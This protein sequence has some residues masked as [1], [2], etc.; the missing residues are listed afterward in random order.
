[1]DNRD[2]FSELLPRSVLAQ[3]TVGRRPPSL[4]GGAAPSRY[5]VGTALVLL[6]VGIVAMSMAVSDAQ[7]LRQTGFEVYYGIVLSV[8]VLTTLL[9]A[10]DL[11]SRS[12]GK[13]SLLSRLHAAG[14]RVDA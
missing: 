7:R 14:K 5:M 10:G 2:T 8:L 1:M 13:G 3:M 6:I 4:S 9:V 11:V 12:L